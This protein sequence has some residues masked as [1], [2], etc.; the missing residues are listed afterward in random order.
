MKIEINGQLIE[1]S[2]INGYLEILDTDSPKMREMKESNNQNVI[3]M[4]QELENEKVFLKN[5][6]SIESKFKKM[7][8]V[9]GGEILPS[10]IHVIDHFPSL[11]DSLMDSLKERKKKSGGRRKDSEKSQNMSVEV[12]ENYLNDRKEKNPKT[13]K[14]WGVFPLSQK[15]GITYPNMVRIEK[16]DYQEI[17]N[18]K[19]SFVDPDFLGRMYSHDYHSFQG[20][21]EWES[22]EDYKKRLESKKIKGKKLSK[23][24]INSLLR[25]NLK[26]GESL[27]V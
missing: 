14:N 9:E 4:Y 11:M 23:D 26:K 25:D 13:Q 16:G 3:L 19:D 12:I 8:L 21:N 1:V 5:R 27:E 17:P 24:R 22:L 18:R 15:Y 2:K 20:G 6:E 10:I 7:E